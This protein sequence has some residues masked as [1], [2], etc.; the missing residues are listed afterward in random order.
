MR[1]LAQW[2]RTTPSST[3]KKFREELRE[4]F[5]AKHEICTFAFK[6]SVKWRTDKRWRFGSSKTIGRKL[7]ALCSD[8]KDAASA[9]TRREPSSS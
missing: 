6:R 4:G 5:H 8:Q 7:L 9:K 3:A 2:L 1:L